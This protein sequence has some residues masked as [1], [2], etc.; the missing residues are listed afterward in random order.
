[1]KAV[2]FIHQFGL[3]SREGKVK[4]AS[5]SEIARWIASGA[6]QVNGEP[7]EAM[8]VMDFPVFSLVVF[9]KGKRVTLR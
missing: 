6:V 8:D 3:F 7:L 4:P 5:K 1:M 2:D 9:P